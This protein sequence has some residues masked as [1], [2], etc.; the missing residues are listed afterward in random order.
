MNVSVA[1]VGG[2]DGGG[3]DV[4]DYLDHLHFFL[5]ARAGDRRVRMA[6]SRAYLHLR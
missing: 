5:Q 2:G 6:S 3:Y 1:L 4:D